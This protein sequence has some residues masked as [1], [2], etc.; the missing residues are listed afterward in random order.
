MKKLLL[1]SWQDLLEP[2][3]K[4][5]YYLNL[6]EFLDKEYENQHVYPRRSEIFNALEFTD[7]EDVKAVILG[8]DPYPGPDE[9]NG[10]AF[11]VRK[12][13]SFPPSLKSIFRELEDDLGYE[14]PN[15]GDLSSWADEG[16][17]LLNTVLTVREGVAN[18]HAYIGWQ[19]FT[20]RIVEL[21]NSKDEPIVFML[22]GNKAKEKRGLINEEKHYVIESTHPNPL[23]AYKGFFGS[24]PFS[25]TNAYLESVGIPPIDWKIEDI[26]DLKID[27]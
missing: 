10:L 9:A 11:S 19:D 18:S 27:T 26:T 22:W 8:Q 7:F 14:E 13:A 12:G 3:M 2:E 20:N 1:N 24:K 23:A 21:L 5:D 15:H 4:K 17:L 16:V 25:K 6:S